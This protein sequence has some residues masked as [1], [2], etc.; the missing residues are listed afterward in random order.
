MNIKAK[1]IVAREFLI[2]IACITIAIMTFSTIYLL[3]YCKEYQIHSLSRDIDTKS[4]F[5]D[6]L[7]RPYRLITKKQFE[8]TE[9]YKS[10]FDFYTKQDYSNVKIW[11]KLYDIAKSDSIK[12]KWETTWDKELVT[13]IKELG[14]HTP[15]SFK[16]FILSN[17]LSKDDI[18]RNQEAT[19]INLE[20]NILLNNRSGISNTIVSTNNQLKI[21][22]FAF[23]I[24]LIILFIFR[25]IFYGVTWSIRTLKQS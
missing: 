19:K 11:D 1:K 6:S 23:L 5:S 10:R 22:V 21:S 8:F 7:S 20:I 13:F 2:F 14:F 4:D 17:N 16:T 15:E 12:Y 18:K 24:S 9:K 25:Y 3:N